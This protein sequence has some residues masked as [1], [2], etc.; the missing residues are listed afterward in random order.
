M[1]VETLLERDPPWCGG[2][3]PGAAVTLWSQ[4]SVVRNLSDFPFPRC[5]SLEE[6][7][8]A[9]QRVLDALEG[10][11]LLASGRYYSL[12]GLDP[13]EARFLAE[14]GLITFSLLCG[15]GPRGVYVSEDQCVS[16]MVNGVNHVCMRILLGGQQLE[17]GWNRLTVVDDTL[18]A[19]LDFAYSERL[20]YLTSSLDC[21]GTGLKAGMLLHLPGL[22]QTQALAAQRELAV[23][24]HLSL[25]GVR[26][27]P[28]PVH[29]SSLEHGAS[30]TIPVGIDQGLYG[31]LGGVFHGGAKARGD[32]YL[33]TNEGALGY[34][35]EEFLFRLRHVGQEIVT[36]EQGARKTLLDAGRTALEDRAGRAVGLA[37]HAHLTSFPEALGWLSSIR[38]GVDLGLTPGHD[39]AALNSLLL[40][41]QGAHIEAASGL[42]CEALAVNAARAS[43]LRARFS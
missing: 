4:C 8:S 33:L 21:V 5:C 40:R 10:A 16:I 36:A 7:R 14:R 9:E 37:G 28:E 20:G 19:V 29:A 6:K 41:T 35:E 15:D 1:I 25:G 12:D 11:N 34:S 38:L 24:N 18:S 31:E 2:E 30:K 3:A 43:L 26:L 32:L 13:Q 42:P 27:G 17:E 39:I 23:R 22:S